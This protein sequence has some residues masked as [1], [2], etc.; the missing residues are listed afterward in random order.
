MDV[1][2]Q[3]DTTPRSAAASVNRINSPVVTPTGQ[4]PDTEFWSDY[5]DD[6]S[7][8][9]VVHCHTGEV[10]A[11]NLAATVF[12]GLSADELLGLT[13]IDPRWKA[14]GAD[15][16][17]LAGEDYPALVTLR[18]H[19]RIDGFKMGVRRPDG[20]LVWLRVSSRVVHPGD[21]ESDVVVIFLDVTQELA[22]PRA[23]HTVRAARQRLLRSTSE[24]ELLEATCEAFVETGEYRL[25]WIAMTKPDQSKGVEA[26]AAAGQ[27]DYVFDGIVSWNSDDPRALG[28]AGIALREGKT[29]LVNDLS[30][31]SSFAPWR[32]RAAAHGLGAILT[33]PFRVGHRRA[34]LAIY[35]RDAQGFDETSAAMLTELIGELEYGLLNLERTKQLNDSLEATVSTL[36]TLAETR[37]PYTAGHQER[38]ADLAVAIGHELGLDQTLLDG[39]RLGALV[40]DIGKISV[41]A[42]ILSKPGP[43]DPV[44]FELIKRH[45]E[46]G[47][48]VLERGALPWPVREIAA[49]HH[50]RMDGSGYPFGLR[51]D[52]IELPARIVAVADVVEAVAHDRPYRRGQGIDAALSIIEDGA[53]TLFDADVVRACNRVLNAGFTWQSN[54]GRHAAES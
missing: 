8:A 54:G 40:H 29:V 34:A 23:L 13:S 33:I 22:Q 12:L 50:E 4:V 3:D 53:G 42:E 25:A 37:D 32:D 48:G 38:V 47:G 15:G 52:E 6:L 41:P 36:A 16:Q 43:L 21:A 19:Q 26:V 39:I 17:P 51:G 28:P 2:S 1:T 45:S 27:V 9:Y 20:S 44:E 35:T 49:Q 30:T 11:Y 31:D 46:I 7:I 10:T 5:L 24:A 14:V 18:T